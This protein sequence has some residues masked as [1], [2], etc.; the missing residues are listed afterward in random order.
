LRQVQDTYYGTIRHEYDAAHRLSRRFADGRVDDYRFDAANNL[1][2][3]PG[4]HDVELLQGNRLKTVNGL[5][6]SY[7]DRNHIAERQTI[8]GSISYEYDSYDQ[9]VSVT[10]PNGKWEAAYDALGRRTRKTWAGRSTEFFWNDDQLIAEIAPDGRLRIY[11]YADGTALSPFLFLD[12][13]SIDSEADACRRFFIFTD[14]IGT[15]CLVEDEKGDDA[16]RAKLEPFGRAAIATGTNIEFNLRFPGHYF[17]TELG[18]HYNRF[19]YYDPGLGRYLQSDP[20]G[21]AGGI[22][23]YGYR[24][25]PLFEVDVL[26]MGGTPPADQQDRGTEGT[27]TPT[28]RVPTPEEEAQALAGHGHDRHGSQTTTAQQTTRVQTG[29]APDG[30]TA[31]TSRATRFDN[32][33]AELDAVR[34]AQARTNA[35]V[36]SG[37]VSTA[38]VVAPNGTARLPRDASTVSGHPGG[39]GSGVEV[40]RNPTTNQPLP[41]RPVQPT[42]QDPNA[43]VV[44]QYQPSTGTWEPVTQYPTNNP[45]TP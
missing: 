19:R 1:I 40:Q 21:I 38:I 4:L 20:W 31:N 30:A 5:S 12:Y 41:G 27:Q 8:D 37:A 26:G 13:D 3:Q 28:P 17:D 23:V 2:Y 15:P 7:N 43:Q 45:V 39:Y 10:M 33:E 25:N 35:R 9:L 44:L 11:I 34:R 22:N 14:Q 6:V 24:L 18:L 36:A 16:W 29:V 32:P 42:G